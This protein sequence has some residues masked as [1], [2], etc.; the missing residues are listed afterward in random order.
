MKLL[1]AHLCSVSVLENIS[2]FFV[3]LLNGGK[4]PLFLRQ[5]DFAT[6]RSKY[7]WK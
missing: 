1:N 4:K 2:S 6:L 5:Y 7:D 3:E